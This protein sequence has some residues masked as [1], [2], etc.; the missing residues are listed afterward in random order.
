MK[1]QSSR[2]VLAGVVLLLALM[3]VLADGAARRESPTFD[4]MAHIGAGVSYLQK[5]DMR[6]NEEHPPLAKVLAALP[7]VVRGVHA[8]YSHVSWTF[9]GSG[10]FKQFLGEWIFGHW[11]ITRW[12]DP[13]ETV[14]WARQSMLFLTLVLGIALF[15][16]GSGIGDRWGGLLCLCAYATM[17]VMLAFGP[18]VLTDIAVT[19]FVV[20]T[21]WAFAS[22]WRT[23][24]RGTVLRFGLALGGALL[25]KFSAGLLFFCFPAF[26]L[27]LRWRPVPEQPADKAELRTW[28]RLRWRSLTKGIF[29]AALVVY[30]VYFVLSWNEPTDSLGFLG[31]NMAA[32]LLRR[33]L[34]PPWIYLR[35]LAIFAFTAKPPSFILGHWYPHGVWFYFPVLFL[36][37]SSLAFLLLLVLALVVYLVAKF[38]PVRLAVIPEG[39][40]LHWRTVW[41]SLVVFTGACMLS[42]F[43]FSIRHFTVSLA[44]LILLLAP[45]PRV[46]SKLRSSGWP[47][48][49]FGVW[50]TVALALASVATAVRAYPYY[51]PFLNSLSGGR[52][53]YVLVADSNLDWNQGLLE[54]ESFVR[55]R[56]LTRV[57]IDAY[58]F[59]DPTVYVP[60]AHFWNC[61]EATS[62]DS[63][64]W[65][66]VS[67]NLIQESHN[68]IW[69]LQFPHEALVGGSMYAF[70]LPRAIPPKGTPGGP[71]LPENYRNFAN[72]SF[73]GDIRLMFLNSILDPQQL[74]PTWDR[75]SAQGAETQKQG[76]NSKPKR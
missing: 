15:L 5:L 74:Q 44:L 3:A 7:L 67:A 68:C 71:P 33:L 62:E 24:S 27:S 65:A 37:K 45:F 70:Q 30:A 19:L 43:Q 21:L 10:L 14:F 50:L 46:L 47:A 9:S 75:M 20:L 76:R 64:Q 52:P 23:P 66:I 48:A 73:P 38:W 22:M 39:L 58:G 72:V 41:V 11:L 56:G 57:L 1:S 35:G 31:H 18:L 13:I 8:D 51:L 63:G 2:I 28:R 42:R 26:V 60:E 29:L 59:S 4:E 6:M 17:P 69:L 61:Q 53:G 54:V 25:S 12:N 16:Y 40:E 34:M 36:L 32:L 49:R 55:Q